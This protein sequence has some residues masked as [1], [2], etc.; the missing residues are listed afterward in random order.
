[1]AEAI[2]WGVSGL[3]I[4]AFGVWFCIGAWYWLRVGWRYARRQDKAARRERGCNEAQG[5]PVE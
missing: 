4:A 2:L 3:V 1:M 5:R